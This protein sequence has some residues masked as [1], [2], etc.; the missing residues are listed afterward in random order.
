MTLSK[1]P[2]KHNNNIDYFALEHKRYHGQSQTDWSTKLK[3]REVSYDWSDKT[4]IYIPVA[5]VVFIYIFQKNL[6][7]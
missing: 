4:S 5:E 3:I 6:K 1:L 7:K 2:H